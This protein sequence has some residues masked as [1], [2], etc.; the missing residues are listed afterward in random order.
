MEINVM[1]KTRLIMVGGF[2]GAGKTT[3]LGQ[4]ATRLSAQ[5][6]RV[7]LITNDQ[8]PDLVDTGVLSQHG[9]PVEEVFGSCFCCNF[10]G[11]LQAVEKLQNEVKA[12]VIIAEPVGSCTDLSATI[13]QPLKDK[14]RQQLVLAPFSVLV[15]PERLRDIFSNG[16]KQL[17]DSAA[18]IVRKQMEEADAIVINKNDLLSS[19]EMLEISNMLKNHYPG[20][21][22]RHLSARSGA[23]VEEWLSAVLSSDKSGFKVVAVDYDTYAEGEA[24][25]GWLN[26]AIRLSC[27]G[28]TSQW[29]AFFADIA[30]G[31]K[32]SF[33]NQSAAVG[34]LKML[35]ASGDGRCVASLTRTDGDT[36]LHCDILSADT[37]S[38]L[39]INARVEMSPEQLEQIVCEQLK[40]SCDT[41][42]IDAKII[43]LKSLMPGRPNPTYRYDRVVGEL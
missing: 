30:N 15:D 1:G 21:E 42:R 31:L 3:L 5:G 40:E 41:H 36:M 20:T 35:L 38:D 6:K 39:I 2:L 43:N 34:H 25:L 17:H 7:G 11:F 27:H 22:L 16:L 28:D 8:A 26:A 37:Q 19:E 10:P 9:M 14:C 4:M 29:Q 23:G 12:D 32:A 13:L 33:Q 24:V 18:Y